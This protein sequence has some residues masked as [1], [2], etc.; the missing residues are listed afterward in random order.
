MGTLR[1]MGAGLLAT[2]L[3]MVA[4][5]WSTLA[6]AQKN[7]GDEIESA[8]DEA[9]FR[10]IERFPESSDGDRSL[11]GAEDREVVD[12]QVRDAIARNEWS[13]ARDLLA[14]RAEGK[15]PYVRLLSGFAAL[16]VRDF[17]DAFAIF[18]ALDGQVPRLDDYRLLWSAKAAYERDD[19]HRAALRASRVERDSPLFGRSLM[20]LADSLIEAGSSTD[21]AQAVDTLEL[22]LTK[23][24]NGLSAE[25]A[26]LKLGEAYQESEAFDEAA[27]A[28]HDV[29]SKHPLTDTA[30]KAAERLEAIDDKI[31][32]EVREKLEEPSIDRRMTRYRAMFDKHK[33]EELVDELAGDLD[34]LDEDDRAQRCE[35]LYMVGRS[36]SKLRKHAEGTDWY[37]RILDECDDTPYPIKALYVGGRGLWNSGERDRAREW[38]ERIWTDFSD[39]SFADDAMYFSARIL[40]EEDRLSDAAEMLEDQVERYP[41]GDMAKDA[42]WLA[43]RELFADEDFQGVIDYVGGLEKTGEDDLYTRGRLTYFEARARQKLGQDDRAKEGY[44]EVVTDE[45]LSYYAF[46]AFNRLGELDGVDAD[47]LCEGDSGEFCDFVEAKSSPEVEIPDELRKAEAFERGS[48]LL[49]L[50]LSRYAEAEYKRL[51]GSGSE[52]DLWALAHLLDSAH[53]YT[54]SHDMVRRHIDGWRERYPKESDDAR[55]SL[56]FPKAFGSV[57]EKFAADRDLPAAVVWAIMREESGFNPRIE[58]WA[59]ARG[60]LQLMEKTAQKV[61]S[62]DGLGEISADDLFDPKIN[63]RLGTG[64]IDELA[65][66]LDDHPVLMIAGYNGGH[67]NVS[68]WLDER[69]DE[70]LDL[71]VEDIPYGQTRKYTKRVL[72]SYWTYAWMY[73]DERVPAIDFDLPTD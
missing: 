70:P 33:S 3:L 41:D 25:E 7:D 2:G 27:R 67:S 38:F 69:G 31:S 43:V 23:Y 57:V 34:Q 9:K 61:A 42:H 30:A 10:V 71:W 36:Y 6:C 64:Y 60:L 49:R 51:R 35:A 55:W 21:L 13:E 48:E 5:G 17:D 40:R 11:P 65:G 19:F 58:S 15:D 18:E 66:K 1:H 50:G 72:A 14:D 20:L 39:H 29:R 44:R 46:L 62:D 47:D 4:L 56:A 16:Q 12:D 22:Y 28:Y 26:R 54:H 68:R 52:E 63:V 73:G 32:E 45:P 53:A 37:E 24:P 59:N 8:G